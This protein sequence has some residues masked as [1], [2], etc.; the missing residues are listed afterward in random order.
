MWWNKYIDFK[1]EDKGR[2]V[3]RGDCWGLLKQIY[4]KELGIFLPDY[5]E[6]YENTMDR[7]ALS[8]LIKQEKKTWVPVQQPDPFDVIILNMRGVPMHVGVVTKRGFMIHCARGVNTSHE[9]YDSVK[10]RNKVVGFERY[11][12]LCKSVTV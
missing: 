5:R 4:E 3:D 6:F 7:H 10:W 2:E 1:F 9:R 8:E 12:G 11:S